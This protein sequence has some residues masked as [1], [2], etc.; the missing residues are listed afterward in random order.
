MDLSPTNTP[1]SCL[2]NALNATLVTYNGNEFSLQND[3]GNGRVETASL[4]Q[5]YI[6]VGTCSFGGIIYIVSYNPLENKSQIGCFPSPERNIESDDLSDF[7]VSLSADEFVELNNGVPTGKVN[8][9]STKKLLTVNNLNPG[10]KFVIHWNDNGN[11]STNYS[12]V[13]NFGNPR[14]SNDSLVL[15]WP[16]LM[17]VHLVSIEDSGKINYLDSTVQWYNYTSSSNNSLGPFFLKET[18]QENPSTGVVDIDSYRDSVSGAYSVFQSKVSGKLALL[19]D[20]ERINTFSASY[21]I[22]RSNHTNQTSDEFDFF[23]IYLSTSWDTD[24]LNVNP[25]GL[26]LKEHTISQTT[27]GTN[28][29]EFINPDGT[30]SDLL[31]NSNSPSEGDRSRDHVLE[32]NY[33]ITNTLIHRQNPRD[34]NITTYSDFKNNDYYHTVESFTDVISIQP[35]QNDQHQYV[36]DGLTYIVHRKSD[37]DD[38]EHIEE[39]QVPADILVNYFNDD[40]LTYIGTVKIRKTATTSGYTY[41]GTFGFTVAPCMEYGVL[42]D[43]AVSGLIDFSQYN[44]GIELTHWKYSVSPN[45]LQL[46]WGLKTALGSDVREIT[47]VVMDFY[48]FMGHAAR[49]TASNYESYNGQFTEYIALNSGIGNSNITNAENNIKFSHYI[50]VTEI[51]P[52]NLNDYRAVY[53]HPQEATRT[54]SKLYGKITRNGRDFYFQYKNPSSTNLETKLPQIIELGS[55]SSLI[56]QR[57]YLV[58]FTTTLPSGHNYVTTIDNY[59]S[60]TSIPIIEY[61]NYIRA[62]YNNST[63][64]NRLKFF[65]NDAGTLYYGRLYQVIITVNYTESG[66]QLSKTYSRWLWNNGIYNDKQHTNDFDILPLPLVLS[67]QIELDGR[68]L[69]EL[70]TVYRS[71]SS[72]PMPIS[73]NFK[74]LGAQITS[75]GYENMYT[76]KLLEDISSEGNRETLPTPDSDGLIE[77]TDSD[78]IGFSDQYLPNY[79][80]RYRGIAIDYTKESI[81]QAINGNTGLIYLKVK[82]G[83]EN[84]ANFVFNTD[85]YNKLSIKVATNNPKISLIKNGTEISSDELQ[86]FYSDGE[87]VNKDFIKPVIAETSEL[88]TFSYNIPI[89]ANLINHASSIT[90][91]G[92]N[93]DIYSSYDMYKNFKDWFSLEVLDKESNTELFQYNDENGET[94]YVNGGYAQLDGEQ[95]YK[96]IGFA[97]KLKGVCYSKSYA[98]SSILNNNCKLLKSLLYSEDSWKQY[99]LAHAQDGDAYFYKSLFLRWWYTDMGKQY[100]WD[101][102]GILYYEDSSSEFN[103]EYVLDEITYNSIND[104][105][106]NFTPQY[107]VNAWNIAGDWTSGYY[108]GGYSD[109][110][111]TFTTN[112]RNDKVFSLTKALQLSVSSGKG[113]WDYGFIPLTINGGMTQWDSTAPIHLPNQMENTTDGLFSDA[114]RGGPQTILCVT[115]SDTSPYNINTHLNSKSF[116]P[117]LEPYRTLGNNY[118]SDKSS[119]AK[120]VQRIAWK[121]N[122]GKPARHAD[123]IASL[124]GQIY[125]WD[126][127]MTSQVYKYTNIVTL[128]P[129]QE[130]WKKD[131]VIKI[132]ID[133]T[134]SEEEFKQMVAL[135]DITSIY[136]RLDDIID[137]TTKLSGY[138]TNINY[139]NVS[140][141]RINNYDSSASNE[142]NNAT[143][144]IS[145]QCLAFKYNTAYGVE[146]LLDC[147]ET[148]DATALDFTNENKLVPLNT[149]NIS[150][151][152]NKCYCLA[153]N[154]LQDLDTSNEFYLLSNYTNSAETVSATKTS[155]L[156]NLATNSDLSQAFILK[157]NIVRVNP[158]F[159][160]EV[161]TSHTSQ[162]SQT[163]TESQGSDA[164]EYGEARVYVSD[165]GM[166]NKLFNYTNL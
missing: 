49:F 157:D 136:L 89:K 43:L 24:N 71:D 8:K 56:A 131:I 138:T 73:D 123:M 116:I 145:T 66:Q 31:Y 51:D 154:S 19:I 84:Q 50:P 78:G 55:F 104:A 122:E 164:W 10:D 72:G 160:Q 61:S 13:S 88:N 96:G 142:E 133:S 95:A 14:K 1:D 137:K 27:P 86:H 34:I 90:S 109:K 36:N 77:I 94:Q 156:L 70:I 85:K 20:L 76:S 9:Y 45:A 60:S 129:Y 48:D 54:N 25:I 108:A 42:D 18:P 33:T 126:G 38:Q 117:L 110:Y 119:P 83:F 161:G 40:V 44:Y 152:Q 135:E 58:T 67:A 26:I 147:Y 151:E 98:Y 64:S 124:L 155:N 7:Q 87:K 162:I 106:G 3:M 165:F 32:Y 59:L 92:A 29:F 82:P 47:S 125:T 163:R 28:D 158:Q 65:K 143:R 141:F 16:K 146:Q 100:Y 17:R 80:R 112:A 4:P 30:T 74:S 91:I 120:P 115:A 102:H 97:L 113:A 150:I 99:N 69:K 75:I 53:Q 114:S 2:S 79:S 127:T 39:E 46:T 5:G 130:V 101:W 62:I 153:N 159:L 11:T 148:S 166:T 139:Q 57:E 35:K 105:D 107:E 93:N 103:I 12:T 121:N 134:S 21:K 23:D 22:T 140:P 68:D 81:Q 149:S 118:G 6:P 15:D 144:L 37:T 41:R 111:G 132:A 128:E 52:N 63:Y